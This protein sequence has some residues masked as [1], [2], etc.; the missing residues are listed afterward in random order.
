MIDRANASQT[1]PL[2]TDDVGVLPVVQAELLN[3]AVWQDAL[4]GF[5]RATK[6]AVMMVDANGTP[7]GACINPHHLWQAG[8]F[9]RR[10]RPGLYPLAT[11]P[12]DLMPNA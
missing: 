3:P 11:P 8:G 2:A 1:L 10:N 4:E 5:A 9:F 6:L 7:I 12:R